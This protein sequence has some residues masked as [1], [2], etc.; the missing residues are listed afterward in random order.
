VTEDQRG[1]RTYDA[2]RR[3]AAADVRRER[4]VEAAIRLFQERGWAGT[5]LV[6]VAAEAGVSTELVAKAFNG[7]PGLLMAAMRAISFGEHAHLQDAFAALGLPELPDLDERLCVLSDFVAGS[8]GPMSA[9][10]AVLN[11]ASDQ[12]P[13]LRAMLELARANHV[14][15]CAE[16]VTMITGTEPQPDQLAEVVLVTR[17]ETWL[18]LVGEL[19]W[20]PE[21]YRDWCLDRLRVSLLR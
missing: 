14:K 18:M 10:L 20:S 19:E 2:S 11:V 21:A 7:K 16:L 12:D 4:V 13:Q 15:T 8:I 3:R 5:R 9:I 17:A 6:D 1:T